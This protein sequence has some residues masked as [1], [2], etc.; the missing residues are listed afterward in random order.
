M[1]FVIQSFDIFQR[2]KGVSAADQSF[3]LTF[4]NSVFNRNGRI[5]EAA[6]IIPKLC[7]KSSVLAALPNTT[8][9]VG[10]T[11]MSFTKGVT[12]RS[13]LYVKNYYSSIQHIAEQSNG[14]LSKITSPKTQKRQRWK[15][16]RRVLHYRHGKRSG[17]L[18]DY[19]QRYYGNFH[20]RCGES[21]SELEREFFIEN[22]R[23]LLTCAR[24]NMEKVATFDDSEI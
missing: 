16:H 15:N 19:E 1:S 14:N 5:N 17:N 13:R 3:Y 20:R 18:Q 4:D 24:T 21:S 8:A 6:F 23:P 22:E 9:S 7:P 2:G 10:V 11:G 12:L